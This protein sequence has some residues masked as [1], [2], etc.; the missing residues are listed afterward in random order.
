M[1]RR[2]LSESWLLVIAERVEECIAIE[3]ECVAVELVG[4]LL[5]GGTDD[6]AGV[7]VVFGVQGAVNQ[8]ELIDRVQV[9]SQGEGIE[10]DIVGIPTAG[11]ERR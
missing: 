8:V 6:A 7:A 2:R 9:G 4:T 10:R 3:L 1:V 5:N 11:S